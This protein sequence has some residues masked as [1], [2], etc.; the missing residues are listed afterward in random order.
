MQTESFRSHPELKSSAVE[1]KPVRFIRLPGVRE[2]T[3]LSRSQLYRLVQSGTFPAHVKLGASASAWVEA[4]VMQWCAERI[5][6]SRK[7]AA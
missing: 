4:E 2:I 1:F 7:E 6:A 5:A 3:G